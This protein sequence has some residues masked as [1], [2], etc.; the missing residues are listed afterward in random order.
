[1]FLCESQLG[2]E[3]FLCTDRV[4]TEINYMQRTILLLY[5]A[6]NFSTVV[7]WV[8]KPFIFSDFSGCS[9]DRLH[10]LHWVSYDLGFR[11]VMLPRT[12]LPR[13]ELIQHDSVY[14]S[15]QILTQEF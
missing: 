9:L 14:R 8:P 11:E 7:F 2:R 4:R 3:R 10:P 1:M 6:L 12:E 5:Y 13:I 15:K